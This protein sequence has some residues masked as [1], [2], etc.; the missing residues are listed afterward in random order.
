[1]PESNS[2]EPATEFRRPPTSSQHNFESD[3]QNTKSPTVGPDAKRPLWIW[4][5]SGVLIL[6][7]LTQTVPYVINALRTV[8]TDDAYVNGHVTFVAPPISGQVVHVLVDDNDRVQR[9]NL[10]VQLDKE[11]YRVQVKDPEYLQIERARNRDGREPFDTLG[12]C[13]LSVTMVSWEIILSKGQ[14]WDW[15]GDPF[16]RVQTLMILFAA[17]LSGLIYRELR[18]RNPLIALRTLTD[19]NFRTCCI[20]IFCA[21]CQYRLASRAVA[22]ALRL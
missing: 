5:V 3:T 11:P 21:L 20:I 18:L 14:E 19:R 8:S 15:T 13:L 4:I 22:V 7:A 2:G 12:L 17:G 6:L 1:M 16:L 10:L 9:G